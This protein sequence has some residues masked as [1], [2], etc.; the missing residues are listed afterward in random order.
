MMTVPLSEQISFA[1]AGLVLTNGEE[2]ASLLE[3]FVKPEATGKVLF[4]VAFSLPIFP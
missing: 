4:F 2:I 1:L 3:S